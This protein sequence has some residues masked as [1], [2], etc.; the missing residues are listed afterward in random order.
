MSSPPQAFIV[1]VDAVDGIGGFTTNLPRVLLEAFFFGL[2][3]VVALAGYSALGRAQRSAPARAALAAC[4]LMYA[5]A[6]AHLG[7]ALQ[8]LAG[9]VAR[10][11][12]L[13]VAATAC[14]SALAEAGPAATCFANG[15]DIDIVNAALTPAGHGREWVPLVFLVI[16]IVLGT[17]VLCWRA[18]VR[19][20]QKKLVNALLLTVYLSS[21]AIY[22]VGIVANDGLEDG[23]G[24]SALVMSWSLVVCAAIQNTGDI[25]SRR[26]EIA[27]GMRDLPRV[28]RVERIAFHVLDSGI[29]YAVFWTVL[30]VW[31]ATLWSATSLASSVRFVHAMR[32]LTASALV[33][34]VGLYPTLLLVL[35]ALRDAPPKRASQVSLNVH[36]LE[37]VRRSNDSQVTVHAPHVGTVNIPKLSFGQEED[38]GYGD[39]KSAGLV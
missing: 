31:C 24:T 29:I 23:F 27:R 34:I 37:R 10:T 25:W 12:E 18:F 28:R 13:A 36:P 19:A 35:G 15:D 3:T 11:R 17:G 14:L 33:H 5:L 7:I 8:R 2:Y 16:N 1:A 21:F 26:H 4:T 32:A 6:T 20:T 30:L 9:D 38:Y 22:I 39:V